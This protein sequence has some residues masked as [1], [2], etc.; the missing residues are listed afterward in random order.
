MQR[1][2]K[3]LSIWLVGALAAALVSN[4]AGAFFVKK[5]L[6]PAERTAE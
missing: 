2:V 3:Y 4:F 6:V 5:A 1:I